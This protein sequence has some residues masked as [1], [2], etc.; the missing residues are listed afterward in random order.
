MKDICLKYNPDM[1]QD[2]KT[3][4]FYL[5][6]QLLTRLSIPDQYK[7]LRNNFPLLTLG[8]TLKGIEEY[9]DKNNNEQHL[10]VTLLMDVNFLTD[11]Q[12][13]MVFTGGWSE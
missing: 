5:K 10:P 1:T 13:K 12:T 11:Y 2:M 6:P 7:I 4:L 9:H 8:G 3:D